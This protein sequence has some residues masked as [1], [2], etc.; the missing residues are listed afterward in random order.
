[1]KKQTLDLGG[2]WELRR[3][4][5]DAV[6][7]AQVPGS[8]Y[9]ALIADGTLPDP[10]WRENEQQAFDLMRHDWVFSRDFDCTP[11]GARALL[12]CDG[13]DTLA[14]ITL[15]GVEAA[16]AD[17]MHI[18]WCWDVTELLHAGRNRIEITFRSPV[19][20]ALAAAQDYPAWCS[21]D[22]VPGYPR[23]R[24]A[25]CMY[26]WDWGPRLPDAGIWRGIRLEL[27]GSARLTGAR[28]AQD[29]RSDGTVCLRVTP[30]IEGKAEGGW[31]ARVT[32]PDGLP[33][34]EVLGPDQ[35]ELLLREP[36]LWWPAGYGG[37]PL[38]TVTVT[39]LDADGA[40]ADSLT[41]RIGLRTAGLCREKD[42]WGESFCHTVNGLK[43]FAMGADYIPEDNI[44][45]RVTPA[46]TRRLLEDARLANF[47]LIRVWGGGY[48]PD[49]FFF[50]IC[51]ELG[52]MV[53]QDFMYACAFYDL[54]PDFEASIRRETEQN[55]RRLRHHPSL[56]LLC[57][58]NEIESFAAD[59]IR[60]A[61]HGDQR[62]F[63]PR[64]PGHFSDYI[65]LFEDVIP[66]IV[67][68]EAP[69]IPWW[70]SSPSSGGSFDEPNS[71]HRGDAHY[72]AVWHGEKPIT[73]YRRHF[74]RY[75]SEYGFQSFPLLPTV[76]TFT[77]PEDRN[78]FSRVMER[79][80]RNGAANGKIMTYLSATYR[81]PE[82]F[83]SLLYASQLLQADAIRCG[84]EHW[85]SHR[86]RCMGA[87]IWQLNDCWPV[88][89]WSS[90]DYFGRW[91]ALHY[92][93]KR[94]F[95]PLMLAAE[96]AGEHTQ[97]PRINE[98]REA[99][100]E[101]SVIFTVCN[102]TRD[103]A[104]C[105]IRWRL[106]G[107][108]G[109]VLREDETAVTAPPLSAVRQEK[110]SFP[111][112]PLT[113]SLLYYELLCGGRTVSSG[114]VLFCAPKHFAFADPQLRTAH[115]PDGILVTS[116]AY[117]RAVW[118][119]S[120]DPDLLL[121]DNGFDMLPGTRLVRVLRGNAAHPRARSVYDLGRENP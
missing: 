4:D 101:R 61:A 109:A 8:V 52:L 25:A 98:L 23:I 113:E 60:A 51:D 43:I 64:R 106:C 47:N 59:A 13:L 41:R 39:L 89:S 65:R 56:V 97:K 118:L 107:P 115:T 24:K 11:G 73:E 114:S 1:M 86:G 82:R 15:N 87:V 50:D 90:I 22:A 2:L 121:E 30:E 78:I 120:D 75:V 111:E 5:E 84:A 17:N 94:F 79:H 35:P 26:G 110:L 31:T 88:A 99:P 36:Q 95:A 14:E 69:D 7:P 93:A 38:Y 67:H 57:G 55:V 20:A 105:L 37:Q 117:A 46:R 77:E 66:K 108:D 12:C 45:S 119:E 10:Y 62:A 83:D 19:N 9:A 103:A 28:I 49:D 54:T 102:E 16:Q 81:Y 91:K 40:E 29:H 76:S 104:D 33:L 27:C 68:K 32:D 92:A 58:N 21:S 96:E 18:A 53:W 85:R 112:A 72:W 116:A 80:Q 48:Y 74:F 6:H 42:E 71:E 100:P 63:S 3:A 34:A 44:L 70:P